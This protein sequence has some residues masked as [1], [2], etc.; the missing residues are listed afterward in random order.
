MTPNEQLLSMLDPQQARLLDQQ[1][2]NQQIQQQSQGAGMLSGLVQAGLMGANTIQGAFSGTPAGIYEQSAEKQQKV[3]EE[4]NLQKINEAK[5]IAL[6]NLENNK[7]VNAQER[8]KARQII[9]NTSSVVQLEALARRYEKTAGKG[10]PAVEQLPDGSVIQIESNGNVREI[11]KP[12]LAGFLGLTQSEMQEQYD[13][14]SLVKANAIYNASI[15]QDTPESKLRDR[16]TDVLQPNLNDFTKEY[17]KDYTQTAKGYA[18]L[19]A[20]LGRTVE[21]LGNANVGS[22]GGIKQFFGKTLEAL[23]VDIDSVENTELVGRILSKEVLNSASLMGG[24]LSDSDIKFLKEMVGEKSSSLEG[25][26]EA[27]I[28]LAV[29]KEVA[30]KVTKEFSQLNNNAKNNFDFEAAEMKYLS[31]SREKYRKQFGLE[32]RKSDSRVPKL[33]DRE[34]TEKGVVPFDSN[35]VDFFDLN[36]G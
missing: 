12:T 9:S 16:M 29:K 17:F 21:A 18:N 10:T 1:M 13:T 5:S 2:R 32:R 24:V 25:L 22:L 31:D 19:E 15:K 27:F 33:L 3:K 8:E 28:E 20:G 35:M 34:V 23:G 4:E 14:S 36:R 30:Y 6:F 26:K 11:T 7:S